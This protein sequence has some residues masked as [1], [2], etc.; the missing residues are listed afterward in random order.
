MMPLKMLPALILL[1][2]PAL[3]SEPEPADTD[4]GTVT[5]DIMRTVGSAVEGVAREVDRELAQ[6]EREAAAAGD[7][8]AVD[9]IREG[10]EAMLQ[11][12]I[13]LRNELNEVKGELEEIKAEAIVDM[14][15]VRSEIRLAELEERSMGSLRAFSEDVVITHD[16]VVDD[17]EAFSGDIEVLGVVRR[18]AKT[19]SGDVIIR[20][21]GKVLG[22]ASTL[23]GDVVVE[24]G[25][26][27][28]GMA[29]TFS[30]DLVV[31]PGGVLAGAPILHPRH[32]ALE[33]TGWGWSIASFFGGL[34]RRLV[35]LLAFAG[36]GV[37]IVALFPDR[38]RSVA[39]TLEE[40]PARAGLLGLAWTAGIVVA[41]VLFFWTILGP[42]VGM[43]V[44]GV[45]WML[46]FVG[47]CQMLGD[48]LPFSYKPHGRWLAFLVGSILMSFL[49]ALPWIGFLTVLAASMF[50]IGAV[51]VSRFGSEAPA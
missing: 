39:V 36:A 28:E 25:G 1:S 44:L 46:G 17:V 51:F 7:Q 4:L 11:V 5:Q 29:Q 30:G 3:A 47:L 10:R 49:G 21:G 33:H 15:D 14:V 6:A 34:F 41:S 24:A 8:E 27:L 32:D 38:V 31:E 50:G 19:F 9:E 45:A 42:L 40:Q 43:A 35:F 16:M 20:K 37:L 2:V 18:D 12:V 23:S 48:R 13:E 26:L 22:N